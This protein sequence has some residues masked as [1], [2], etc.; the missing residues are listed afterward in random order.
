M[1]ITDE[2]VQISGKVN[3]DN[4]EGLGSWITTNRNS[5]EGLYSTAEAEK[6]S[7]LD[8]K[9]SNIE[10]K[11]NNGEIVTTEK[12]EAVEEAITWGTI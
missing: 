10:S 3:A 12:F 6:L 7:L 4:V 1:V 9:I 8:N 11:L 5:I 2:G